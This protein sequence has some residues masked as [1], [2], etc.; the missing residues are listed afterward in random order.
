[1]LKTRIKPYHSNEPH[2]LLQGPFRTNSSDLLHLAIYPNDVY[3]DE[4]KP[5][6]TF[7]NDE[8]S[9]QS[10]DYASKKP[11]DWFVDP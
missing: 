6:T 10:L 7:K 4:I 11:A 1:M 2:R 3:D 5:K 9:A 8:C